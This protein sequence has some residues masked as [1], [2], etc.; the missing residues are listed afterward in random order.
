[1]KPRAR[2][3]AAGPRRSTPR[4]WPRPGPASTS[5][6]APGD[7]VTWLECGPRKG[8]RTVLMQDLRGRTEL[9]PAPFSARSRVHEY[10]GGSY[11]VAGRDCL[12]R[13]RRGPGVW[14]RNR[15]GVIRRLTPAD[16]RRYADLV[17]DPCGRGC[18]PS[19]RTMRP[20][21][22]RELGGGDRRRRPRHDAALRQRFLRLAA[23]STAKARGW[24][25]SAW[26]HPNL[27]WDGTELW[28]ACAR[29]RRPAGA[30]GRSPAASASPC[31]SPSG[32]A[33]AG[34]G[35]SP[36]PTAG[37]TTTPGGMAGT[38]RLT[39]MDSEGGLPQWVFGQS[40]WGEVA[41]GLLGAMTRDGSWELW[42]FGRGLAARQFVGARRNRAP[43]H[44]RQGSGRA[45]RR[46]RPA[47]R[48]VRARCARLPAT[49][50]RRQRP[51]AARR[52][53]DL[54]AGAGRFPDGDGSEAYAQLLSADQPDARGPPGVAPPVI[55]K[56]HGGPTGGG[57]HGLR[58]QDPVLDHARLRGAGRQLSRQHRLR[59]CLPRAPVRA[60]GHRRRRGLR[61]G[62]PP[63]RGA[64][65][66][67]TPM[68]HSSAAAARADSLC[69]RRWHSPTLSAPGR[70]ITA[71]ATSG[72]FETT[73]KFESHY[74]H[75]LFGPNGDPATRRRIE[76]RSPLRHAHRIRCPV[77][78]FQGG[79]DR[80]VP[81][82]QSRQ[83]HAALRAAGIPTAYLEFPDE[84]HGFRRA[85]N[86]IVRA[87]GGAGVLLPGARRPAAATRAGAGAR[88][89]TPRCIDDRG[90]PWRHR[91]PRSRR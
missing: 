2:P 82:E 20:V 89:T 75:W 66:S 91:V 26:N 69:C 85:E 76:E 45:G 71:S 23:A 22:A 10:G 11:C 15:D 60:L 68:R 13:Q 79:E 87:R 74:D 70:A 56:C 49:A 39:E 73:H 5:R 72:L 67:R 14:H 12:V 78:F 46:R 8:G 51:A 52:G 77:I 36:I 32:C 62:H 1:M 29:P 54:A 61:G 6:A 27:P 34:W 59:P 31:S 65:V 43:G 37:G 53:L 19:A 58:R 18:W 40:T 44:R 9:T 28:V 41:G 3:S 57:L 48:R 35:S 50:A 63:S 83:M 24:P 81:P 25:G 84:R 90:V 17:R 42:Q 64:R 80:V 55:V 47:D 4:R 30:P 7:L 88:R 33:T 86:I 38:E 21:R 16:E